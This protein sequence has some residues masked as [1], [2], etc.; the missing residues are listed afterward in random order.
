M[1][2]SMRASYS[3]LFHA[4]M[5]RAVYHGE[6]GVR[7]LRELA[8]VY[9]TVSKRSDAGQSLLNAN[10]RCGSVEANTASANVGFDISGCKLCQRRRDSIAINL[11]SSRDCLL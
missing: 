5:L 11:Q 6:N 10:R 1:T 2:G 4:G 7:T 9:Q 8:P 3:E